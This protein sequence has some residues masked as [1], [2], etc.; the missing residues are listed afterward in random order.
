MLTY[1]ANIWYR[2]WNWMS[3][4]DD[5]PLIISPSPTPQTDLYKYDYNRYT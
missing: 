5:T 2:F 3:P 4:P 1:I